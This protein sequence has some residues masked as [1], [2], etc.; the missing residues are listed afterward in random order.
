[1]PLVHECAAPDCKVLTMGEY[2]MEHE[3]SEVDASL[4]DALTLATAVPRL[5]SVPADARP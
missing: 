3:R 2:C 1:M 5:D 4:V